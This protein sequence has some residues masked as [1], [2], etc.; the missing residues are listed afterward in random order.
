MNN[1]Q[2]STRFVILAEIFSE[3]KPT[4]FQLSWGKYSDTHTDLHTN[5]HTYTRT[6]IHFDNFEILHHRFPETNV[7]FIADVNVLI[8]NVDDSQ[9]VLLNLG[10]Y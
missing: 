2:P 4:N 6:D 9:W 7:H 5:T 8:D 1:F 3:S 10:K